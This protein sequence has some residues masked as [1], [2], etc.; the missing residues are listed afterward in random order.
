MVCGGFA[1]DNKN[2]AWSKNSVNRS[3]LTS[4]PVEMNVTLTPVARPMLYWRSSSYMFLIR[5]GLK[6]KPASTYRSESQI[7]W[8]LVVY[9]VVDRQE[10]IRGVRIHVGAKLLQELLLIVCV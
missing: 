4:V 1:K 8:Q 3:S 2:W 9:T 6:K 7:L 5:Y 10:I